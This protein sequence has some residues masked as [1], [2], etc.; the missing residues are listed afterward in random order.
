[1]IGSWW[2]LAGMLCGCG[3]HPD[4]PAP[5]EVDGA[6]VEAALEWRGRSNVRNCPDIA[7][8]VDALTLAW[9]AGSETL[10]V[11][12]EEADWPVLDGRPEWV[13]PLVQVL[14]LQALH[15]QPIETVKA[16]RKLRRQ[17]TLTHPLYPEDRK[18][19][20]AGIK[21]TRSK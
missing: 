15:D 20:R 2:L 12:I 1:M 10:V 9:I 11:R 3:G 16:T 8:A 5:G 18:A 4:W 14:A 13:K 21:H 6:W 17:V 7:E 19:F